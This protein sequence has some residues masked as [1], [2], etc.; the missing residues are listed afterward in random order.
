RSN[1]SSNGNSPD[2]EDDAPSRLPLIASRSFHKAPARRHGRALLL[3]PLPALRLPEP[4][5][6]CDGVSDIRWGCAG[7]AGD[8]EVAGQVDCE[9]R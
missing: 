6:I 7:P 9:T 4:T 5:G 8:G 3:H 1:P 2:P